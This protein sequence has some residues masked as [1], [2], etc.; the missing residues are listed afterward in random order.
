[1]VSKKNSR[2]TLPSDSLSRLRQCTT[3]EPCAQ[4]RKGGRPESSW[5]Q[6][7]RCHARRDCLSFVGHDV[8]AAGEQLPVCLLPAVFFFRILG[9]SPRLLTNLNR[10]SITLQHC[11]WYSH[12]TTVL[13][14]SSNK[15]WETPITPTQKA[16]NPER[17]HQKTIY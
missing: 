14:T 2:K 3:L 12:L 10:Q 9:T 1:L 8:A 7:L 11:R 5:K 6:L 13:R 4:D 17:K 15:H 16:K